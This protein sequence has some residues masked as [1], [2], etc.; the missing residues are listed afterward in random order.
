MRSTK[1]APCPSVL[2]T[3]MVPANCLA[4]RLNTMFSPRPV[5][6]WPRRV[7]TKGSNTLSSLQPKLKKT[8]IQ[9]DIN[10]P[11]E[12]VLDSYP[13]AL[14]QVITN[15]TLNCV[16]HAFEPDAEGRI[17]INARPDGDWVE[18]Q[19][20][21]N[22]KGIPPDML[23]KVFDPFV[24]TR[25]GQGG[26]GLGLNIVFNL[27]AKQFGGTITVT[28]TLGQGA[29]FVLR[30]PRVTP[31]EGEDSGRPHADAPLHA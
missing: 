13:G 12:I 27:I 24:T 21:D 31:I 28:S 22:G 20:A 3:V 9:V 11:A 10:C 26:T 7:V 2:A 17:A 16:E 19:V 5:P 14:A 15:L 8:H 6:P 25:R 30:I 4:I 1:L 29:S 18:M 23:D